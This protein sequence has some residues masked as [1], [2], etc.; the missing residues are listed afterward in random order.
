VNT[1]NITIAFWSELVIWHRWKFSIAISVNLLTP[2]HLNLFFQINYLI[3]V[4]TWL[5]WQL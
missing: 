3:A 1:T 4:R 2:Q 5:H